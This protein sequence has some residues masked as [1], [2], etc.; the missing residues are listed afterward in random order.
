MSKKKLLLIGN[1]WSRM[2]DLIGFAERLVKQNPEFDITLLLKGESYLK[3]FPKAQQFKPIVAKSKLKQKASQQQPIPSSL[4]LRIKNRIIG[5]IRNFSIKHLPNSTLT[6]LFVYQHKLDLHKTEYEHAIEL[7]EQQ[8]FDCV[9]CFSDNVHECGIAYLKGFKDHN[10]PIITIILINPGPAAMVMSRKKEPTLK[11]ML[12][13]PLLLH[14]VISKYQEQV[15]RFEGNNYLFYSSGSILA[16]DKL[17]MLNNKPFIRGTGFSDY[18]CADSQYDI[19]SRVEYGV[20]RDKLRL[21]G[22][23]S[24]DEN[25]STYSNKDS[26]KKQLIKKYNLDVNKKIILVALPQMAEHGYL[27]WSEHHKYINDILTSVNEKGANILLSLHP[28]MKLENY[29]HLESEFDCHILSER[30]F[31]VLA[32]ADLYLSK[33]S[34]TIRWGVMCHVNVIIFDFWGFDLSSYSYLESADVA[35]SFDELKKHIE[36][37]LNTNQDF[38]KTFERLSRDQLFDGN[39]MQRYASLINEAIDKK[40]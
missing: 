20:D 36:L 31:E 32:V 14:Y 13:S 38:E 28:K 27:S 40:P 29:Q 1:D 8:Q 23:F 7:S 34:S 11:Q 24:L 19:E 6:E 18:V 37:R 26:I 16:L 15:F 10:I 4:V 3:R 9:L 25:W 39:T 30:L 12:S 5:E 22:D 21:V 17:N 33:P 2:K 35:T